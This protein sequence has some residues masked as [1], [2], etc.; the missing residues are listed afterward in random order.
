MRYLRA[1]LTD[2]RG[3]ALMEVAFSLPILMVLLTG[4]VETGIF[5]MLNQKLQHSAVAIS[6][7]TTRDE[8]ISEATMT[9]IFN[10]APQIMAPFEMDS[11]ARVIVSAAG[12][13]ASGNPTIYWQRSGAGNLMQPSLIGAEGGVPSLPADIPIRDNETIVVTEVFFEYQ[14]L[15]FPVIDPVLLRRTAYFRPRI[16]AL[17]QID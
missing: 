10:A 5:L 7:L 6:D 15:F 1:F 12:N 14:P 9:D 3:A 8:E 11:R 2:R 13:D 4:T 16:G 17:T